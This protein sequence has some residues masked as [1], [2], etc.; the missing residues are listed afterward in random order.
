VILKRYLILNHQKTYKAIEKL[1]I[2]LCNMFIV[3]F[4]IRTLPY[5]T[6]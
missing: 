5:I 4:G 6:Q 3:T 2:S 1:N